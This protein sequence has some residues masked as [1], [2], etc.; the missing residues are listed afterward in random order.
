[1]S[2]IHKLNALAASVV[3]SALG[4]GVAQAATNPFAAADMAGGY[5]QLAGAEGAC[6]NHGMASPKA[7]DKPVARADGEGKC[8]EGKCGEG[9]CGGDMKE[10]ADAE[11]KCGEGKCGAGMMK[12]ELKAGD[13]KQEA[14]K[15]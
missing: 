7:A 11:G 10:K 9:K 14:P 3:V 12:D 5:Q 13:A 2:K 15:K 8:G 6:G 4:A 1:M